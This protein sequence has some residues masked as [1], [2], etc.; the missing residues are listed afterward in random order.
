MMVG[1]GDGWLSMMFGGLVNAV[2]GVVNS[3]G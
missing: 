3:D 2:M 1:D